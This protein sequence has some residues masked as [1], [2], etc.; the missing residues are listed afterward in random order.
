MI[1]NLCKCKGG[2]QTQQIHLLRFCSSTIQ[3]LCVVQQPSSF[4]SAFMH[5]HQPLCISISLHAFPSA[6]VHCIS[7]YVYCPEA[8]ILPI[9]LCAL[10][11]SLRAL[12][13]SP[14]ALLISLYAL[15]VSL[16]A[17]PSVYCLKGHK[18]LVYKWSLKGK[19][20]FV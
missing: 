2:M 7:A 13:V 4:P 15:S 1:Y 10:S 16:H 14:G 3:P 12:V 6:F 19:V 20:K 11:V 8:S 5:S 17:G 9:S 18:T